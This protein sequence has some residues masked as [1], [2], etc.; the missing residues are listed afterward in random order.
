MNTDID[1]SKVQGMNLSPPEPKPEAEIMAH[2]QENYTAPLVSIV[3][4]TYNHERYIR[5]ALNGFLMQKTDYPFEVLIH[6]DASKDNTADIIRDYE[7]R[8]PNIIKP[9][10]QTE[11]Q[12]SKGIKISPT[13]NFPRAQGDYIALCEGDDFWTCS[14]KLSRQ[15]SFLRKNPK[16]FLS[17]HRAHICMDNQITD[18]STS[19]G[20]SETVL[21]SKLVYTTAGQFCPTASM[22][23][24]RDKVA[25]M[26][27]FFARVPIGD[28]FLEAISAIGGVHYLPEV[29]SVYRL[30]SSG[31]WT[32]RVVSDDH[33]FFKK[34]E[35][36]LN[37][38][39]ELEA[40][41][42]VPDSQYVHH[43]ATAIHL[44]LANR[45][46]QQGDFKK[47]RTHWFASF[48]PIRRLQRTDIRLLLGLLRIRF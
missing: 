39:K 6:D 5:D 16:I 27:E 13:F 12:Y 29:C 18:V 33:R 41:L 9:I 40:Y 23:I 35:R 3:C 36:M 10:Y 22:V 20:E 2:W 45:H 24:A 19:H 34:S 15:V 7:Q 32:N 4:I 25:V 11:N 31:S 14:D 38:L 46:L 17:I 28:F 8:Y 43:K 37:S 30:G 44:N 48:K 21:S 42:Q 1:S 47:Y 26:P